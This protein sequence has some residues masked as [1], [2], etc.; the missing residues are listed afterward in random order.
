MNKLENSHAYLQMKDDK[1][2]KMR[3]DE[4]NKE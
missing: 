4:E 2:E 1:V 3:M